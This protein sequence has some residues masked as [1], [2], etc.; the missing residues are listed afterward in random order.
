MIL[1]LNSL[2]Q[3]VWNKVICLLIDLFNREIIGYNA[4]P[5]RSCP[6]FCVLIIHS[7]FYSEEVEQK[8]IKKQKLPDTID[9]VADYFLEV[10]FEDRVNLG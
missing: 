4:G 10:K 5:K 8:I 9:K 2:P 3:S 6:K 1:F 7:E